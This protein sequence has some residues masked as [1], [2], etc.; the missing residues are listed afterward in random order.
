M[1]NFVMIEDQCQMSEVKDTKINT[2][3]YL[4]DRSSFG[5]FSYFQKVFWDEKF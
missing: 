1:G 5:I 4:L 2:C 3:S